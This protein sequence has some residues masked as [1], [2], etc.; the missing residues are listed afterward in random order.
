MKT[1]S[2]TTWHMAIIVFSLLLACT[3]VDADAGFDHGLWTQDLQQFVTLR[4]EGVASDVN[5]AAWRQARESLDRY[6][7]KLAAVEK[8]TYQSWPKAQQLAFLINAYNAYTVQLILDHPDID[9]IKDIGGWFRQPWS[10]E[11]ASLLGQTRSLDEIEHQLI[12]SDYF[13]EPRIHFA[14][15]CASVGC[16]LLRREAYVGKHLD[17]QLGDQ[18]QRFLQDKSR[19][20]I[21]G[22]RLVLSPIFK[23]YRDDFESNWGGYNRLEDFL[24]DHPA[25]LDLTQQQKKLL[26]NRQLDIEY[27]EYDWSLNQTSPHH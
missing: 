9:S 24:L 11:F 2:M 10:I 13:S 8:G 26:K 19:N 5:Y 27:S 15:N 6:L 18:T 22:S 23:W 16:P 17:R 12:R 20:K 14:V 1:H 4:R 25:A 3:R 21:V 7:S